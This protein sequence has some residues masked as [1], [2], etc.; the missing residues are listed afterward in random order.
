MDPGAGGF[1]NR[2]FVPASMQDECRAKRLPLQPAG[3]PFASM[4]TNHRPCPQCRGTG[5]RPL[6]LVTRRREEEPV[7]LI[8]SAMGGGYAVGNFTV[9][10]SLRDF[11]SFAGFV[12]N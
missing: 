6:W 4:R 9:K 12:R 2:R 10:A 3:I 8:P 1:S 7:W 5:A 11:G